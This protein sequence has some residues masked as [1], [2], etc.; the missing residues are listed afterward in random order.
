MFLACRPIFAASDLQYILAAPVR[1]PLAICS[2]EIAPT[3][4]RLPAVAKYNVNLFSKKRGERRTGSSKS[5]SIGLVLFFLAFTGFG[6]LFLYLI[7]M[8]MVVPEWRA[9]NEYLQT[10]CE[11]LATRIGQSEDDDGDANFRPEIQIEYEVRG[12]RYVT[13]TYDATMVYT[14]NRQSSEEIIE[15]FEVGQ[16]YP[17]WYNPSDPSQAVVARGY[18]WFPWL[19]LALPLV[20]IFIGVVGLVWSLR[21]WGKSAERQA[22]ESQAGRVDLFAEGEAS[23]PSVPSDT[24]VTNSPGTRLRYRLPSDSPGWQLLLIMFFAVA[25]NTATLVFIVTMLSTQGDEGTSWLIGAF[26]I[27]FVLVGLVLVYVAVK[28]LLVWLGVGQT[29]V[30][31]SQH[32]LFPGGRYQLFLSQS[33]QLRV[34]SLSLWLTCEEEATYR[35]GTD[36]RTSTQCVQEVELLQREAFDIQRGMPFETSCDFEVP[37]GAMHSFEAP[38]NKVKWKLEVRGDIA[39]WPDFKRAYSVH[40]YPA[41]GEQAA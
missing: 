38:H 10:T 37:P 1:T 5:G 14:T 32:P 4:E 11:V 40:V 36:T 19:M 30:E 12:Q 24:L 7:L 29:V 2:G 22:A 13:W 15:R 41:V 20:F 8:S 31:I 26:F 18:T 3:I 27:P 34:N 39:G 25:W 35:Q 21:N 9:N 28:Q 16:Q 23:L 17:C 33:G 6:G